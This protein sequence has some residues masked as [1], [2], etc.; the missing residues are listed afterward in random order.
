MIEE[1]KVPSRIRDLKVY[2]PARDFFNYKRFY[3]FLCLQ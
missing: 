2:V 3:S 1:V